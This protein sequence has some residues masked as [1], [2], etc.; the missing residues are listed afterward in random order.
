VVLSCPA[1]LVP[2]ITWYETVYQMSTIWFQNSSIVYPGLTIDGEMRIVEVSCVGNLWYTGAVPETTH[3]D[4]PMAKKTTGE[5]KVQATASPRRT[6]KA[7]RLDLSDADHARLEKAAR[8][9]GLNMA[10][11]ARMA[12]LKELK[13]IEEENSK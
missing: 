12:T 6:G 1:F 9:M 4:C 3:G 7:V 11:F 10:S 13:K 5:K 2:T 8:E